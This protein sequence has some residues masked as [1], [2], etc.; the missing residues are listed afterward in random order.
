MQLEPG[1]TLVLFS[2]G[3]TEAMDPSEELFGVPRLL[4]VL[5][6][7]AERPLEEI[8]KTILESVDDFARGAHQVD[9]LTLLIIRYR[10]AGSNDLVSTDVPASASA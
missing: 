3:V 10:A 6:G 1:D 4:E 9:D 2:D 5:T 7:Q 8:Q